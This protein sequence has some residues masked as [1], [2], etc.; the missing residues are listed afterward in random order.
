MKLWLVTC[1]FA[2]ALASF[3]WGQEPAASGA[4]TSA[5]RADDGSFEGMWAAAS[6]AAAASDAA[7]SERLMQTLRRARAERNVAGIEVVALAQVSRGLERLDAGDA[8]QAAVAFRTA[9]D[10]DPQLPEGYLGLAKAELQRGPLGL[11]SAA[12]NMVSGLTAR[13]GT[14]RGRVH[15]TVL[16][17]ASLLIAV[18]ASL[19]VFGLCMVLRYGA[20]LRHDLD[21]LLG[22]EM[23]RPWAL[24]LYAII[25][26]SPA[27]AQQGYGWLPLWWLAVLFVYLRPIEK[28]VTA[29]SLTLLVAVGPLLWFAGNR[30]EA[31]NN[32]LFRAALAGIEGAGDARSLRELEV[33]RRA[34]AADSDFAYLVAGQLRKSGRYAEASAIYEELLRQDPSDGVALNNIGNIIAAEGTRAAYVSA[35]A[36]YQD[37]LKA[38]GGG[39]EGA[40]LTTARSAPVR[41]TLS[42][43][44]YLAYLQ[45]FD[46]QAAQA[47]RTQAEQADRGLVRDYEDRWHVEKEGSTIAAFVDLGP[48]VDE[49]LV[50]VWGVRTGVRVRNEMKSGEDPVELLALARSLLNRFSAAVVVFLLFILARRIWRGQKAFTLR[51]LKCGTPFCRHCHLGAAVAGLCTQC[52]HLFVV[53]DGVSGPARN[54][55]L[56]EVQAEDERR[57][58]VFRILSLVSPG[59][60]HVY[61]QRAALGLVYSI[62][63]YFLIAL[64]VLSLGFISISEAASAL[65]GPW[66]I[67]VAIL[68]L[69]AVYVLATRARLSFEVVVPVR[70]GMTRPRGRTEH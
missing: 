7:G 41:A 67:I 50:K 69:L 21:E 17:V 25:L 29:L 4:T 24:G 46:F 1:A 15:A 54:Q 8:Q 22:S 42:Y 20:L 43:N 39:F 40:T 64:C 5:A 48:T 9:I 63:W 12:R 66:P 44:L 45:V 37:G 52:Y 60:G 27:I 31:L 51:C 13:L 68:G 62:V 18:V 65:V 34:D 61:G 38:S 26:L 47:A 30:L 57:E 36:R 3:V 28:A 58:R 14:Y 19:V 59:A 33:A 53:R 55:K 10:L 35:I 11:V 56:L 16:L 6:R 23:R 49:C 2:F 32:P 70:R